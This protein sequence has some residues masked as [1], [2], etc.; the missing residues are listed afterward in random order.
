MLRFEALSDYAKQRREEG[1]VPPAVGLVAE[2]VAES[3]IG[4]GK[5]EISPA[6]EAED[7]ELCELPMGQRATQLYR[8]RPS[9]ATRE[10][11]LSCEASSLGQRCVVATLSCGSSEL[12]VRWTAP[13]S[14]Q[15][16]IWFSGG[17]VTA[18]SAN[19][20]AENDSVHA[21]DEVLLPKGDSQ[22]F[23][24]ATLESGCS[25]ARCR[26]GGLKHGCSAG[27]L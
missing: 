21:F 15:G 17:F 16:P 9:E 7:G 25:A 24:T 1:K 22:D 27:S 12:R 10:A 18:E 8:V 4:T 3:G 20:D 11:G 13:S 5:L 14:D 19:G 23:A 26:P 6:N 2:L